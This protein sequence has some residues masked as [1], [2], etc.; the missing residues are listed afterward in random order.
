MNDKKRHQQLLLQQVS[1]IDDGLLAIAEL[2]CDGL[3]LLETELLELKTN[4][5]KISTAAKCLRAGLKE[6]L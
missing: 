6:E 3:G 4:L 2:F 1:D 5:N